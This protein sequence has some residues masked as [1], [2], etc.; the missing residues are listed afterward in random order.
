[1]GEGSLAYLGAPSSVCRGACSPSFRAERGLGLSGPPS[2][3]PLASLCLHPHPFITGGSLGW[4]SGGTSALLPLS[5]PQQI[6]RSV[7]PAAQMP[8]FISVL[9][10]PLCP[11]S[12][13]MTFPWNTSA[14]A[15]L[16][17]AFLTPPRGHSATCKPDRVTPLLSPLL[18]LPSAPR[19]KPSLLGTLQVLREASSADETASDHSRSGSIS[20]VCRPAGTMARRLLPHL[21]FAWVSH[22]A[23]FL[24]PLSPEISHLL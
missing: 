21:T 6:S 3:S 24:P 20:A 1:M 19:T 9:Y 13:P 7:V 15:L 14:P 2:L 23:Y 11:N 22:Q 5:Q 17:G 16:Q 8:T 12:D 10:L 18:W 4:D